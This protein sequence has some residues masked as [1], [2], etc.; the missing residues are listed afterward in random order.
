MGWG[1]SRRPARGPPA[2]HTTPWLQ[3]RGQKGLG[4]GP[5]LFPPVLR[6]FPQF[7]LALCARRALC[8]IAHGRREAGVSSHHDRG[9]RFLP[10]SSGTQSGPQ[11]HPPRLEGE[12][13]EAGAGETNRS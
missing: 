4:N 3:T 12:R 6:R 1:S 5:A 13:G 11:H 8:A 9:S 2:G 10:P 7:S